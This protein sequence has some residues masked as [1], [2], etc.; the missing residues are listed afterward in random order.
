MLNDYLS[1]L[2]LFFFVLSLAAGWNYRTVTFFVL[3]LCSQWLWGGG[4][5]NWCIRSDQKAAAEVIGWV[6]TLRRVMQ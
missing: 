3:Q 2:S 6:V 5:L 4:T 1:R